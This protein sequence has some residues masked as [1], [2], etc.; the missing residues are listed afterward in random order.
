MVKKPVH[1]H[2][3]I[4]LNSNSLR[5]WHTRQCSNNF[6]SIQRPQFTTSANVERG[7]KNTT[8]ANDESWKIRLLSI[9]RVKNTTSANGELK[10]TT[11]VNVESWKIQHLQ[12]KGWNKPWLCLL[13]VL[14]PAGGAGWAAQEEARVLR[15]QDEAHYHK[16]WSIKKGNGACTCSLHMS[17][18]SVWYQNFNNA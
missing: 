17:E 3:Y 10:S 9:W 1:C 18:L 7:L 16:R 5:G 6:L 11:S 2:L 13:G 14:C 4:I 15:D 8:S 12:M